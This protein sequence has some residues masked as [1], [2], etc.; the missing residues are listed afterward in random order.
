MLFLCDP[1]VQTFMQSD[2]EKST[3]TVDSMQNLQMNFCIVHSVCVVSYLL[4]S[5]QL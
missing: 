2:I 4:Q 1:H 5:K 3:Y